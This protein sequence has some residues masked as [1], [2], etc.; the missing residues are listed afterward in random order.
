MERSQSYKGLLSGIGV[1]SGLEAA[2][3]T[4]I[5]MLA[6][7]ALAYAI[8]LFIEAPQEARQAEP[9]VSSA[10]Q[11]PVP[12]PQPVQIPQVEVQVLD[13]INQAAMA[14]ESGRSAEAAGDMTRAYE[15]YRQAV[16][17]LPSP[18]PEELDLYIER[19][20]ALARAAS[21]TG[22]L[23][24]A[25]NTL[26]Q[27]IAA[28]DRAVN[29]G[30]ELPAT[31]KASLTGELSNLAV[32][33]RDY[34][35]AANQARMA[36]RIARQDTSP[37]SERKE[38]AIA[39][40]IAA[41]DTLALAQQ[42]SGN[43]ADAIAAAE[44]ALKLT[45]GSV[46]PLSPSVGLR[47]ERL[48]GLYDEFGEPLEGLALRGQA[49]AIAETDPSIDRDELTINLNNLA[50]AYRREGK[51]KLA[52]PLY[53]KAI[54]IAE[55]AHGKGAAESA[56]P[57]NNLGLLSQ[58][59]GDLRQAEDYYISALDIIWNAMGP[60]HDVTRKVLANVVR[61]LESQGR[62]EDVSKLEG[63]YGSLN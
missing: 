40:T 29:E 50:E 41:L 17:G 8:Y 13:S 59:T 54:L 51:W 44:E 48:A 4:I 42:A 7:V 55:T 23:E 36:I 31:I 11:T 57:L 24:D 60:D 33:R 2:I 53:K 46:G 1:K 63:Q 35:T 22:R 15:A 25:E 6:S 21:A 49:L 56:I 10:P 27:T 52:E 19:M 14:F 5:V 12:I 16:A 37:G 30:T 39:V 47:L 9:V 26:K 3:L 28:V 61:L 32:K 34:V 45:K 38:Q 58:W 43:F 20:R 62:A 18:E